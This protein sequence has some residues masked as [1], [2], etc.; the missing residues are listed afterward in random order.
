MPR[1]LGSPVLAASGD[2]RLELCVFDVEGALWHIWQGAWSN[3]WSGWEPHDAPPGSRVASPVIALRSGDGRIEVFTLDLSG[4][5]WNIRQLSANGGFTDWNDFATPGVPLP[6]RPALGR[7]ADG[8]LELFACGTDGE[9]YH[10]WET[11]V[12]TF[13]WSGWVAAGNP[14]EGGP[15][16]HGSSGGPSGGGAGRAGQRRRTAG[17]VRRRRRRRTVAHLA[18]PG[19]QR[20]VAVGLGWPPITRRGFP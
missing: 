19:Q 2:G 15:G 7:S 11:S 13:S 1:L 3:G 12:G 5:M 14:A 8:R 16:G 9:L 17:T 6:G 4:R 18:D 20:L 10:Q